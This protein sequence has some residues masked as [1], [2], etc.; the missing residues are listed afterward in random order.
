MRCELFTSLS[1]MPVNGF[2]FGAV[3]TSNRL[4]K[5]SLWTG[6]TR[7]GVTI[8]KEKN[9]KGSFFVAAIESFLMKGDESGTL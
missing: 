7:V 6:S 2:M 9:Q 8:E 1:E 5:M 3:R 4:R